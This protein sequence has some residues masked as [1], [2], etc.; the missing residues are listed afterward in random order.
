M[1][2]KPT[3]LNFQRAMARSAKLADLI[4]QPWDC[5]PHC[6]S[7]RTEAAQGLCLMSIDHAV[8]FQ[9]LLPDI[10]ASAMVLVRSQYESLVRAVWALYAAS[11]SELD[12]LLAPLTLASQQAAKKLP[13]VPDM[14]AK[15]ERSGPEG[16]SAMFQRARERMI[17]GL[18]SFV[19]GG[20]QPFARQRDGYPI[21]FLIDMLGNSNALALLTLLVLTD[22]TRDEDVSEF[23]RRL[24]D[25]FED[26]LPEL[27]PYQR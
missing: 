13:G 3:F 26:V 2:D 20:I 4:Q 15:L 19:H 16:A 8:A 9:R 23:T 7:S 21:S 12:R 11:E 18:H 24:H 22:I 25:E 14:I 17:D 6:E 5:A 27:E 10:P 1:D